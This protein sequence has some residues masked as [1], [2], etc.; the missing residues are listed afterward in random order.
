[1]DLLYQ[2]LEIKERIYALNIPDADKIIDKITH[3]LII[4]LILKDKIEESYR[5]LE[6]LREAIGKSWQELELLLLSYKS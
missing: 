5:F 6:K 2:K 4:Q 1:V 3:I